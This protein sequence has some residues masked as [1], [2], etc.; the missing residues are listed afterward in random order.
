[1][2]WLK[3]EIGCLPGRLVFVECNKK[4]TFDRNLLTQLGIFC[5]QG[6]VS[7][8]TSATNS[9]HWRSVSAEQRVTSF[10]SRQ[11]I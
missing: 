10:K 2:H 9:V 5:K 1:M 3:S 6:D 8:G 7:A 11:D 4:Q